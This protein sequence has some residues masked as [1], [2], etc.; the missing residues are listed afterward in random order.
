[1]PIRTGSD[2][3]A[4]MAKTGD[5]FTFITSEDEDMVRS[6]E[7]VL[8]AKVKRCTLS[9]F[10]YKKA[11]LA[12]AIPSSHVAGANLSAAVKRKKPNHSK[13]LVKLHSLLD[14]DKG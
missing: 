14:T 9:G 8:R 7:R 12:V 11:A 4:R 13:R 2:V 1:M 5:A 6:I 10:D 3:L